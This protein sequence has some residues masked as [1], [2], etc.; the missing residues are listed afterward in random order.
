M[1]PKKNKK[2]SKQQIEDMDTSVN[3]K[4][5]RDSGEGAAKKICPEQPKAGPSSQSQN[6]ILPPPSPVP[7]P[8]F[9]PLKYYSLH[10]PLTKLSPFH[11]S[12]N[13]SWKNAVA[14]IKSLSQGHNQLTSPSPWILQEH[15]PCRHSVHPPYPHRNCSQQNKDMALLPVK[16]TTNR[17]EGELSIQQIQQAAALC[18]VELEA[19]GDFQLR[20]ALKPLLSL[21]KIKGLN[22]SNPAN[23]RSAA[24]V[25]TFVR[26]A[27]DR[28]KGVWKFLST[29]CQTDTGIKLAELEHS[30]LKKCIPFCSG[31]VP[32]LVHPSLYRSLKLR[33]PI[34]VGGITRDNRVTT[35]LGTGSLR[36]AVGI[37]TP[38]DFR[39]V[40]DTE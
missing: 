1:S 30:S 2:K 6:Q 25:T 23:F 12:K 19:V 27:G 11:P 17:Q 24:M 38:K 35:E 21:E 26:S 20:K 4:R 14:P 18:S 34:D 3:L 7:P 33:F 40:V 29:V 31:R 13:N 32:I 22:V 36:Q 39:P 16:K 37:L 15:H 9:P 5:R 10:N 8:P 28:T